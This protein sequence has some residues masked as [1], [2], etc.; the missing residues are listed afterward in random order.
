M[1]ATPLT[2]KGPVCAALC[3]DTFGT[4]VQVSEKYVSMLDKAAKSV[5]EYRKRYDTYAVYQQAAALENMTE[6]EKAAKA[7]AYKAAVAAVDE[8]TE[9][10]F[11]AQSADKA[12][13]QQDELDCLKLTI[14]FE[15]YKALVIEQKEALI[16]YGNLAVVDPVAAKAYAALVLIAG[17][18][19]ATVLAQGTGT[20]VWE[21]M[22]F[23]LAALLDAA[24]A[25]TVTGPRTGLATRSKLE[26]Y[27]PLVEGMADAIAACSEMP[28]IQPVLLLADT[29]VAL[30]TIDCKLRAASPDFVL[31]S[32]DDIPDPPPAEE[33]IAN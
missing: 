17:G 28:E 8:A 30:R 18:D 15:K 27:A 10:D 4:E 21:K 12:D 16:G 14:K 33:E 9:A 13:A 2:G 20:P 5:A 22:K 1:K 7:E 32:D 25:A 3:I 23:N 26:F 24:L 19:P 29:A 11:A 31:G 6:E